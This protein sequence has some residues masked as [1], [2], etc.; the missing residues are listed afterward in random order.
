[1][2]NN[3]STLAGTGTRCFMKLQIVILIILLSLGCSSKQ[4]DT[5][6]TT[7]ILPVDSIQVQYKEFTEIHSGI[8]QLQPI[9]QTDLIAHFDGNFEMMH[10]SRKYYR[11]GELLFRLTGEVIDYQK[12]IYQ[13]AVNAART[14]KEY[15]E[16][17]LN[18]KK[19]L[20]NKHFLSPEQWAGLEKNVRLAEIQEQKADSALTYFLDQINFKAPFPGYLTDIRVPQGAFLRA[21]SYIGSYLNPNQLKLVSVWY[22]TGLLFQPQTNFTILFDDTSTVSAKILFIDSAIDPKTG[23]YEIWFQLA[24]PPQNFL[25]GQWIEYQ[26]QG[27][28][29]QS[30]AIPVDALV[31]EDNQYWVM[32]LQNHISNPRKVKIGISQNGWVEIISGLTDKDRVIINGVYELFYDKSKI[33]YFSRD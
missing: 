26:V 1:M 6:K 33:K 24:S 30:L 23:G 15:A 21:N 8:G 11:T 9:Q 12:S 18:R 31:M 2:R 19:E 3:S 29:R 28:S 13:D 17:I 14:E 4:I 7:N 10:Y 22:Q 25:A 27:V 20:Y 32:I 16:N 5:E